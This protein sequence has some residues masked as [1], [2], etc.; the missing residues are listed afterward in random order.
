MTTPSLRQFL[1]SFTLVAMALSA[2]VVKAQ[3]TTPPPP[4]FTAEEVGINEK[5]G[6][7]I[8]LDLELKDEDGKTV[9]LR[10]LI[11]KPTI[12][13]LNYF[14]CAGIC[15]HHLHIHTTGAQLLEEVFR[16]RSRR[17]AAAAQHQMLRATVSQPLGQHLAKSTKPTRDQVTTIRLHRKA[18]RQRLATSHHKRLRE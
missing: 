16:C 1:L 12:L 14:R 17:S 8:P 13:T 3:S 4:T 10:Q 15:Q 6:A 2:G 11:D 5:L 7:T 9:T 18:R